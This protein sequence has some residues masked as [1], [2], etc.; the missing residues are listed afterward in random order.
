MD[1]SD[2]ATNCGLVWITYFVIVRIYSEQMDEKYFCEA[3][4][5]E[6]E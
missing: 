2:E 4:K 6:L 5:I 3:R 1:N